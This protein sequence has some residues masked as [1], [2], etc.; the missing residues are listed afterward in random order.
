VIDQACEAPKTDEE[1][2]Q[3][4]LS[5]AHRADEQGEVPVG[6]VLVKDGVVVGEGW[7]QPIAGHDPTAHAEIMALRN[8]G[9]AVSNYR[10]C[11]TTLYVSLEPCVMCAGAI[12]HSRVSKVVYAAADL[13]GGAAG[14]VF[15][16]LGTDQLNHQVEVVG[17]VMA[18]AAS[19]LLS[20]FFRRRRAE[21]KAARASS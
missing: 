9:Q 8:A 16:I 4:A 15:T 12:I 5:L 7:N 20:A 19:S 14:S 1:W 18:E 10:L 13:K 3:Y 2:M 17:G 6:A 11:D 21:K